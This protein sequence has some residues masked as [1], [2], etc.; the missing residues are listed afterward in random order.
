MK[1]TTLFFSRNCR[2]AIG[3]RRIF[4]ANVH[5][6]VVWNSC[7]IQT[8]EF[9]LFLSVCR[10]AT[11]PTILASR[12][13]SPT[14]TASDR[15]EHRVHPCVWMCVRCVCVWDGAFRK[16]INVYFADNRIIGSVFNEC[17][18][19]KWMLCVCVCVCVAATWQL[20]DEMKQYKQL[21][22]N[23]CPSLLSLWYLLIMPK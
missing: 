3:V 13:H 19:C 22:H 2:C 1:N 20:C 4:F 7:W 23:K 16:R 21:L 6:A 12:D 17:G 11:V 14:A 18:W 5:N 10:T 15:W 8:W 9:L